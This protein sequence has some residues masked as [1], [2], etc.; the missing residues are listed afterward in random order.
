MATG[1]EIG[2][3]I[4][5]GSYSKIGFDGAWKQRSR[6]FWAVG[7]VG[8]VTG[9]AIGLI[10]PFIP[11]IASIF[12]PS[13]GATFSAATPHILASMAIF[14]ATGMAAGFV[15]GGLVGA[16]A[17]G[18]SSVAKEME[19]RNLEREKEVEKALGVTFPQ[20]IPEKPKENNERY[21][22]PKVGLLFAVFG[23]VAG[24]V[25]AA[26]YIYGGAAFALPALEAVGLGGTG[27]AHGAVTAYFAGVMGCFGA[28]FGINYPKILNDLQDYTG[29]LLGGQAIGT[30]WEKEIG[31]TPEIVQQITPQLAVYRTQTPALEYDNPQGNHA[32]KFQSR[33]A[34]QVVSYRE[35]VSQ[36]STNAVLEV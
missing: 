8:L 25:M 17:G 35:I 3:E 18:P 4:E 14:G 12:I 36:P 30:S 31:R 24:L 6:S 16:A 26:S 13:I 15:G 7:F 20:H 9:V 34:S 21:F 22:N 29:T 2:Q 27:A 23:V 28:I 19:R 5:V 10:A 1:K 33:S 11:A 32:A